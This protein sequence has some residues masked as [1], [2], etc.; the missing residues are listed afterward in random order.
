MLHIHS[1]LDLAD[2]CFLC[3]CIRLAEFAEVLN[4]PSHQAAIFYLSVA[5]TG[6]RAVHILELDIYSST[7]HSK[8]CLCEYK[9]CSLLGLSWPRLS[10]TQCSAKACMTS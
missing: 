5:V 2:P 3:S 10:G 8:S 7:F 6:G 4:T 1:A 9:E